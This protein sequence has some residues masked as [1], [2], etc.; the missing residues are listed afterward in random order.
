M[1]ENELNKPRKDT[2][3]GNWQDHMVEKLWFVNLQ[4]SVRVPDAP[5]EEGQGIK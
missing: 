4:R 5:K 1:L 3:W 2:E